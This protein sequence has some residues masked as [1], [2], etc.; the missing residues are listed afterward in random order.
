MNRARSGSRPSSWRKLTISS[1]R[2]V[3]GCCD[4]RRV[5]LLAGQQNELSEEFPRTEMNR[6][7]QAYLDLARS[8]KIYGAALLAPPRG[9]HALRGSLAEPRIRVCDYSIARR[10]GDN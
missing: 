6:L 8:N 5:A 10:V 3:K 4:D 1:F 2:S 7:R 9:L